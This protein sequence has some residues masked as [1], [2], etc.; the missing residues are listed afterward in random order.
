MTSLN[1]DH[2][3]LDLQEGSCLRKVQ[4]LTIRLVYIKSNAKLSD[5]HHYLLSNHWSTVCCNGYFYAQNVG[6]LGKLCS[7]MGLIQHFKWIGVPDN[8]T[9]FLNTYEYRHLEATKRI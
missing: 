2:E 7:S 9:R 6:M 3:F 4:W 1:E 8:Q 5:E